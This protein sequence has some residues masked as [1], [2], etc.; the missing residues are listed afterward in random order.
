MDKSHL[1][2]KDNIIAIIKKNVSAKHYKVFYFGSR[3]NGQATKRSDIDIGI[4]AEIP[5]PAEETL[6]IKSELEEL[7]TLKKFDLVDFNGIDDAFKR[8]ALEH[9][10]VIYEQ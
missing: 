4:A 3:V 5:L 2:L 8:V 7:P 1:F 10:E 9:A 6:Q